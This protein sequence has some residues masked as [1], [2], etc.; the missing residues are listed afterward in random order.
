MFAIDDLSDAIDVTRG[1]LT[2]V[3][4]WT[5]LKLALLVVFIGGAGFSSPMPF[6]GGG[7]FGGEPTPG[8]G[9]DPGTNVDVGEVLPIIIGVV[10]V[11]LAIGLVFQFLSSLFEFT[12]LESLRSGEVHVR[13]YTKRN[14]GHGARLF[15]FRV[16]LGV[17]SLV[18]FGLPVLAV[19][20]STSGSVSLGLIGLLFL[21]AIPVFLV[22]AIISRFT[23]VF[24]APTMLEHDI[25]VVAAWK[26]FWPTLRE[27]WTEYVVYLVLVWV[28]QLVLALATGILFVVLLIPLF[29][30][31][32]I[33]IVGILVLLI[34]LPVIFLGALLIQV[35][36]VTYLRYYALLVLGDTN[37]DLDLIPEQRAA[38]RNGGP[39][40]TGG[41]DDQW[42]TDRDDLE[43]SDRD[44]SDDRWGYDD[45]QDDE[46]DTG[47]DDSSGWDDEDDNDDWR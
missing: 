1:F 34:A 35:P 43:D 2:P 18:V 14:V 40:Q 13:R 10:V 8:P 41:R 9:A 37:A 33:P 36:I 6:G 5:W 15:G 45:S 46:D 24:V 42:T 3:R 38:V 39:G 4:L 30:L 12:F 11:V 16:A 17:L 22:S 31:A 44:Q 25:G 19:V 32:L 29:L 21:V 26:R 28:L 23:T 47:W 27:H 20:F 7:S